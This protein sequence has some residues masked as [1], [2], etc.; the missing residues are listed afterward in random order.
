MGLNSTF[1]GLTGITDLCDEGSN[2]ASEAK[3]VPLFHD[4]LQQ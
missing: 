3:K 1:K 4:T 2:D